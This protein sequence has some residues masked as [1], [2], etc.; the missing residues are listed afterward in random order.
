MRASN[1]DKS[2]STKVEG[3][4]FV[5][6]TS[7]VEK[8]QQEWQDAPVWAIDLYVGS[9]EEDFAKE[10][11]ATGREII[12]TR[13]LMIGD[14][15]VRVLTDRFITD[16]VLFGYMSNI[17]FEEY[18]CAKKVAEAKEQLTNGKKYVVVGTGAAQIAPE[19][20]PVA[21]ADMARWEIQQRYRR[22]EVKA[23]GIDNSAEGP[24]LQYKRGYFND[25]NIC[26]TYKDELFQKGRISFW[27]DH[28][29]RECPKMITDAQFRQGLDRKSVV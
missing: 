27:I 22:H 9:Y 28:N 14:E 23:L 15:A 18:F 12:L 3:K 4:A 24:S 5:G 6:W 19:N 11:S 2:P 7:I 1:F 17:R 13:N 16:D 8:L 21:Y 25:W 26:D 20:A 10:F 29:N